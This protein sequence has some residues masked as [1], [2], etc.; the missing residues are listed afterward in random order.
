MLVNAFHGRGWFYKK[1]ILH[2]VFVIIAG[3]KK[4]INVSG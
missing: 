1:D 4:G 3:G 2:V